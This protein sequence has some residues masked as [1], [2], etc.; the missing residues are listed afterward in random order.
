MVYTLAP[1]AAMSARVLREVTRIVRAT[2]WGEDDPLATRDEL[3]RALGPW[4]R[5]VP[6][7]AG[8][9]ATI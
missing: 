6:H 2:E 7:P 1:T 4:V 3:I 8:D 5:A 9:P